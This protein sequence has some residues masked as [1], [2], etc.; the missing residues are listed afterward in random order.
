[1]P[2]ISSFHYSSFNFLSMTT[3]ICILAT[4]YTVDLFG[5]HKLHARELTFHHKLHI[6]IINGDSFASL[7]TTSL[8][9]FSHMPVFYVTR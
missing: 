9:Q 6:V 8:F 4:N 1:M 7:E 2:V 3:A 5:Y